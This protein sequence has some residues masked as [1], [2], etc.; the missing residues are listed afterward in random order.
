MRRLPEIQ[1]THPGSLNTR[2]ARKLAT[3]AN[4]TIV[5]AVNVNFAIVAND[6]NSMKSVPQKH[7]IQ[8]AIKSERRNSDN[9]QRG[10]KPNSYLTA[11]VT[12]QHTLT[13]HDKDKSSCTQY[14]G[15][16]PLCTAA[17]L[18][19]YPDLF[20]SPWAAWWLLAPLHRS[21]LRRHRA[22]HKTTTR[23]VLHQL[24]QLL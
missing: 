6:W 7:W 10:R 17:L 9:L 11:I 1:L 15:I 13:N 24:N 16:K 3:E 19:L 14:T 21:K 12:N 18:D 20:C 4:H 8:D 5:D 2:S 22:L 23:S